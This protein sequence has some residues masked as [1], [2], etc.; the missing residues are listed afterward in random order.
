MLTPLRGGGIERCP[1]RSLPPGGPASSLLPRRIAV[2]PPDPDYSTGS[3]ATAPTGTRLFA[4]IYISKAARLLT[5]AELAH[6]AERAQARNL[7]ED[8][9]GLLLYS[10]GAFMQYIEG[11]APGMSRIYAVIKADPMHYG[12]IDLLREAIHER[13]FG[14]WSMTVR[15]V[16]PQGMTTSSRSD[17]LLRLRLSSMSAS[18]QS[19]RELLTNF[20]NHGRSTVTPTLDSYPGGYAGHLGQLVSGKERP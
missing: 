14:G 6:L 13:E 2:N 4:L 16:G 8:V 1:G 17:E 9:T 12:M 11:P 5:P 7:I 20:W 3:H 15:D 18:H 19:A 10:D